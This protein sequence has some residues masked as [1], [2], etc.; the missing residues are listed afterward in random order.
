VNHAVNLA[1]C[2]P[3]AKP[4]EP[5]PAGDFP[6]DLVLLAFFIPG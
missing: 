2:G 1:N 6:N 4:D 3:L 5:G